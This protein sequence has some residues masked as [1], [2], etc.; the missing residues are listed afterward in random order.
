MGHA[1]RALRHLT[2]AVVGCAFAAVSAVAE[3]DEFRIGY[4]HPAERELTLSLIDRPREDFGTAGA[5]L[6]IA[7]NNTTGRFTGQTYV[8]DAVPV[9]EAAE[10]VAAVERLDAAGVGWIVADLGAEALLEVADA[11]AERDMLVFNVGAPDDDLRLRDCRENLVHVIPSRAMLAD[12]LAQYLV[13]K[14]WP[15]W[16]LVTGSHP[17][18]QAY[19]AA[20]RRAADRF[21]GRVV[22]ERVFADTG[23]ARTTDTG[24]VQVQARMPVFLQNASAHDVVVVADESEVFGTYVPYHT[25]DP[26]PIA[27]TAGL[28]PTVWSSAH[29]QWGAVQLQNRFLD[30]F[31]RRMEK[32]DMLAWM[33]VRM[34]GEAATRAGAAE[35]QA[36][37]DFMKGPDFQLAGFKGQALTLR[38]WNQQLRQPILLADGQ[39]VVTVSPQEGFLHP[40]SY[41][42]TLGHDRPESSCSL[43][44]G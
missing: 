11:A 7:D 25:W 1:S 24:H 4:I 29:E 33:A 3:A 41:L 12:A 5:E 18:D 9:G 32:E 15:R 35:R 27:G 31:G 2:L 22:E 21:G 23:G 38:P 36:I 14:K 42:D 17:E 13:W 19:A 43:D 16:F 20:I 37:A 28:E 8:L 40:S 34:V 44:R 39:Q 10:A 6:A 26:R 30:R